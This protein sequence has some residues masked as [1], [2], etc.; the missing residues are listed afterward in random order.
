MQQVPSL[1]VY[2]YTIK[3]LCFADNTSEVLLSLLSDPDSLN[4][5]EIENSGALKTMLCYASIATMEAYGRFQGRCTHRCWVGD[6]SDTPTKWEKTYLK[7]FVQPRNHGKMVHTAFRLNVLLVYCSSLTEA[8][9][10][11]IICKNTSLWLT[12]RL[13]SS[14]H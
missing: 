14:L 13:A 4:R 10:K 8:S 3:H 5:V 2:I 12:H 9:S 11:I 1:I 6:T 7:V